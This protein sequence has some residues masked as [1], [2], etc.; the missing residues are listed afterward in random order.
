M[1]AVLPVHQMK[2][3]LVSTMYEL[4]DATDHQNIGSRIRLNN[5]PATPEVLGQL[6]NHR[7]DLFAK[8]AKGKM[9]LVETVTREDMKDLDA[10]KEKLYLFFTASQAY[11]WDFHL[12]CFKQIAQHLKQFCRK[13]E[14]RYSKLWEL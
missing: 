4:L 14:I 8:N 1:T 9:V 13:Q 12:V 7:P 3:A 6:S 2:V 11:N 10:L 5:G